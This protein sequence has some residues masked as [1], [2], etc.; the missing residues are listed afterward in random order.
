[1][2]SK[3][4]GNGQRKKGKKGTNNLSAGQYTTPPPPPVATTLPPATTNILPPP[5]A[6]IS[7]PNTF[8]MPPLPHHLSGLRIGGVCTSTSPFIDSATASNATTP[9]FLIPRFKEVVEYD[10]N[11]RLII[12]RDGGNGFISMCSGGNM[13]IE[14]IKPF[15][16]EPWGSWNEI[17]LD[18]RVLMWNQFITKC[19]WNSCH[20]NEIQ[21]IFKLKEA[22]RIKEHLYEARKNLKKTSWMNADVWDQF[23]VKWDTPEFRVRREWAKVNRASEMGGSLR[24]GGSMSFTTHRRRLHAMP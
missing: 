17:K 5:R 8:F 13:I 1:M 24:T 19:A 14:A 11:N 22:L 23:F 4:H 9:A 20:E 10:G 7:L 12:A 21:H 3:G 6:N 2:V 15:Y 16:T 18:V